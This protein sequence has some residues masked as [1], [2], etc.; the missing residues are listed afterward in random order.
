M[1]F[2][3]TADITKGEK[4]SPSKKTKQNRREFFIKRALVIEGAFLFC[5]RI[6]RI[7]NAG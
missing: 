6:D 5:M 3:R 4:S 2:V 7:L 1:S